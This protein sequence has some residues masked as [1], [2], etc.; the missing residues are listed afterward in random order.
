MRGKYSSAHYDIQADGCEVMGWPSGEFFLNSRVEGTGVLHGLGEV[1]SDDA[2]EVGCLDYGWR[3]FGGCKNL[4]HDG[5]VLGDFEAAG[6]QA[7]APA[8]GQDDVPSVEPRRADRVDNLCVPRRRDGGCGAKSSGSGCAARVQR[9]GARCEGSHL[10]HSASIAAALSSQST[11]I[12]PNCLACSRKR[13]MLASKLANAVLVTFWL[14]L[15]LLRN[16]VGHK[17]SFHEIINTVGAV[18]VV[19]VCAV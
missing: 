4:W 11:K 1:V 17:K 16:V 18:D 3:G 5:H 15:R 12:V 6:A 14:L 10:W 19:G 8:H 2:R 9:R 7:G 13:S